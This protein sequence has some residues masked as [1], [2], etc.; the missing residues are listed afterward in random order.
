MKHSLP[1]LLSAL[2]FTVGLSGAALGAAADPSGADGDTVGPIESPV[3][4]DGTDIL[5][6]ESW[7][8]QVRLVVQGSVPTPCHEPVW[9]VQSSDD[10]ITVRLWSEADA[11]VV[12]TS[13]LAPFEVSIPLGSFERADLPV[14]LNGQEVGHVVVGASPDPRSTPIELTGAGWSFGMC[15]G[16]CRADLAV[17]G[18]GLRLQ[19]LDP[20]GIEQLFENRGALTSAGRAQLDTL[21]AALD[22]VIL[23]P[24]YGCPDCAD[25]GARYV[26]LERDGEAMRHDLE[27]AAPPP[28]LAQ[29]VALTT[30]FMDALQG[31]ASG[32][33]VTVADDCVA[34]QD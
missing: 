3:Y 16:F 34:W 28:E 32:E 31:C 15:A 10:G 8:V 13:V 24:V 18:D 5:Y 23:E 20:A 6:M 7:P 33:L 25:G 11:D 21:L 14:T 22:G 26:V 1:S 17:E 29:L 19:G 27:F 12:C 30:T 4:V 2:A 9:D